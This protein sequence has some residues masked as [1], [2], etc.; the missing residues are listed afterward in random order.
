MVAGAAIVVMLWMRPGLQAPVEVE[1]APDAIDPYQPY[2]EKTLPVHHVEW[3]SVPAEAQQSLLMQPVLASLSQAA[4]AQDLHGG[5]LSLSKAMRPLLNDCMVNARLRAMPFNDEAEPEI[6]ALDPAWLVHNSG[7]IKTG[8]TRLAAMGSILGTEQIDLNPIDQASN[9][10]REWGDVG[11]AASAVLTAMA[12]CHCAKLDAPVVLTQF[13]QQ[14]V[15][16]A[17]VR[18]TEEVSTWPT[19][20]GYCLPP[21]GLGKWIH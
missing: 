4:Q 1:P 2:W 7:P 21:R 20:L 17:I 8:G 5:A 14:S 19:L 18:P 16:L 15:S 9:L 3:G 10:L 12:V 11:T 13:D 6:E